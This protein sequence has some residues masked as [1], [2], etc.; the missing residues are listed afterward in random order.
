MT[1]S[2]RILPLLTL[3]GILAAQD[4]VPVT[5]PVQA[6]LP[7]PAAPVVG[8]AG[9]LH[10]M[11]A[12]DDSP[13]YVP[14][15]GMNPYVLAFQNGELEPAP[16]LDPRLREQIE[17]D[18]S[19]A[20]FAFVMLHGR[21]T[22]ERAAALTALGVEVL[23]LHTWQCFKVRLPHAALPQ[24][25]RADFVRWVGLATPEQK[26]E[27]GL[28]RRL[29]A[30]ADAPLAVH[31][32]LFGSDLGPASVLETVDVPAGPAN[33]QSARGEARPLQRWRTHGACLA[34][35]ERRGFRANHYDAELRAY[36]GTATPAQIRAL[37]AE[38]CVLYVEP[39]LRLQVFHEQ[40][41]GM[42]DHDRVR[43]VRPGRSIALG[44]IDTGVGD[45]PWHG[46]LASK[47]WWWW[48][49]TGQGA[50]KDLNGHGTHVA[51][52]M[53]GNGSGDQ[54][55][56]G[57]APAVGEDI[58]ARVF[59]GRFLGNDGFSVGDPGQ[60]Y[61]AFANSP[62]GRRPAAV[63]NS[64][65]ASATS[66]KFIGS[67]FTCRQVDA[68]VYANDITY[69]FAA[70]NSGGAFSC[71]APAVAKN[72]LTVGSVTNQLLGNVLAGRSTFSDYGCGDGRMKPDV[73]APG[74]VITSCKTNTAAEYTQMQGTSMAAPHVTG[75]IAS[76]AQGNGFFEYNPAAV[77]A[78]MMATAQGSARTPTDGTG[79][80]DS[81][82]MHNG[83]LY[84]YSGFLSVPLGWNQFDIQVPASV[85]SVQVVA[86]WIEGEVSAGASKAR[87]NDLET[88]LDVEPYSTLGNTGEFQIRSDIDNT[89]VN[90]SDI[91]TP[92][93]FAGTARGKNVRVKVY[94]KAVQPTKGAK[95]AVCVAY[96]YGNGAQ[97][98]FSAST[99]R[100]VVKP[101]TTITLKTRLD[102]AAGE[103]D[104]PCAM[105]EFSQPATNPFAI[106]IMQRTTFDNV[107]HAFGGTG[108]YWSFPYPTPGAMVVGSG[109][110]RELEF[111]LKASNNS[112]AHS[113]AARARTRGG[114]TLV[115]WSS[116]CVDG[117]PPADI[118]GLASS[119]HQPNVWS[120]SPDLVL[121]WNTPTDTGCAGVDG[122]GYVLDQSPTTVP[123][124]KNLS[125][126]TPPIKHSILGIAS[127]TSGYWFALRTLDRAGNWSTGTARFGPVLIDTVLPALPSVEINGNATYTTAATVTLALKASDTHSGLDQMS[128]SLD[129]S[130]WST[131]TPYAAGLP[132]FDLT[133]AALGGTSAEGTKTV[134]ARVRDRAGNVS[135]VATD[136]IQY[137]R[138]ARIDSI[139]PA[140]AP[141]VSIDALV[142]TGA[143]F[144][145]VT[146]V[147]FG[148]L[149][150]TNTRLENMLDGALLVAN[151]S[152]IYLHAPQGLLP[153]Q[154]SVRLV[155]AACSSNAFP[156]TL[157]APTTP[158]LA[159][160]TFPKAGQTQTW[161]VHKGSASASCVS[162]LAL[163]PS[164][165]PSSLPGL[166][167]LGIGANFTSI[168][169]L[170]TGIS[171]DPATGVA[172]FGPLPLPVALANQVLHYQA[173]VVDLTNPNLRPI[174]V[175]NTVRSQYV[176]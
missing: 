147:Q 60:L 65:G 27:P 31:V 51:G 53:I 160:S 176:P 94:A 133:A 6:H 81:H 68:T 106:S 130:T 37:L 105:L 125:G 77:R 35:L 146:A 70:G 136:S 126:A 161:L 33:S 72:A 3:A 15:N 26:L 157:A 151:D 52:T 154:Y 138:C 152:M 57:M 165:A 73:M 164:N 61:N 55:E 153:G 41:V 141:T 134:H 131:W 95:W 49:T 25:L 162:Y 79:I 155:N 64:W 71:G 140:T 36:T 103:E 10:R 12:T 76:L 129:G 102:V 107:V 58:N 149:T 5:V 18:P 22:Q 109:P 100:D 90:F 7:Q 4:R 45:N 21:L 127:S 99:T 23:G 28:A 124:V 135:S 47:W 98:V 120:N 172:R 159:T 75:V 175:T 108:G 93:S 174:P 137:L 69:V 143:D 9:T 128:F 169:L 50:T 56:L 139:A 38:D 11:E 63:N 132:G 13:S 170:P 8:W 39:V 78:L 44:V 144:L 91:R 19:G 142:L 166:I 84:I 119:L 87:I 29:D 1:L 110:Y 123:A 88:W 42:L 114:L 32:N 59:L 104:F 97:P 2:P 171:N 85:R 116:V 122:L 101:G 62:G 113:I 67:E 80:V 82:R 112:G 118:S 111:L 156:V 163:S 173:L 168:T 145:G 17:G 148:S 89:I 74:E 30:A 16:G 158:R 54:R 117:L 167:S 86:T 48:D 14:G 150:I 66:A 46:D 34:R 83:S 43:G 121:A 40:S 24:V 92:S 96:G 20:T 115:H